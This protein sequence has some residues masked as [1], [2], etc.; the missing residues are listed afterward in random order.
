M[1]RRFWKPAHRD[2]LLTLIEAGHG[3]AACAKILRRSPSS[4]EAYAK[5]HRISVLRN[6]DTLFAHQVAALFGVS[7]RIVGE[8]LA[9]GDLVGH[10]ARRADNPF[11]RIPWEQVLTFMERRER[12]MCWTPSAITDPALHEWA[13]E[14]RQG[15]TWL[16]AAQVGQ[17]RHVT[18][19]AVYGWI[20][21]GRIAATRWKQWWVWSGDLDG[22]VLP[23]D[24]RAPRPLSPDGIPMRLL[25]LL[26]DTPQ[27]VAALRKQLPAHPST[28]RSAL[29][30]L[31]QRGL[32]Q[33]RDTG[34]VRA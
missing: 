17:R 2:T 34:W 15:G 13:W 28:V 8:W 32:A 11:W 24:C 20:R 23:A 26:Q 3:F 33:K 30:H 12:W 19:D 4:V 6:A 14:L 25:P 16:T 22:F 31:Q 18:P 9:S 29:C 1:K 27:S 10:N 5:R 21:Q 7:T